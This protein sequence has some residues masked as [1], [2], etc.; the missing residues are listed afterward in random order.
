MGVVHV[1]PV[2]DLIEHEEAGDGC[3]CGPHVEFVS[4]GQVVVHHSLDG[5]ERTEST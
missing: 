4:G 1:I 3:P 2:D 5:R